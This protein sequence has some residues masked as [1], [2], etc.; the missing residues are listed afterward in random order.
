MQHSILV[1]SRRSGLSQHVIRAWEKRYQVLSPCRCEKNQRL[2]SDED[3]ERLKLL[4]ELTQ[5]GHR[6]GRIAAACTETLHDLVAKGNQPNAK[7]CTL[8]KPIDFIEACRKAIQSYESDKLRCLLDHARQHL[9]H[10]CSLRQVVCPLIAQVGEAWR[11]GHLGEAE[12]HLNTAVVREFLAAPIAGALLPA[13]APELI[14]TT[15]AGTSHELGALLV[16][17]TA[18]DL[19]WRVTYLGTS[20]PASEI[21]KVAQARHAKAVAL[22]IVYPPGCASVLDELKKLRS[23]LPVTVAILVGGRAAAAYRQPLDQEVGYHW[24]NDLDE[25]E[26]RITSLLG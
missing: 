5:H 7:V 21:S 9:G 14:V 19:G 20:L 16:A 10:R 22:S 4:R 6:I 8:D 23:L 18:R 1:A 2:Y 25:F 24:V 11:E 12:E 26:Q 3:I 15:P 17:A 13:N